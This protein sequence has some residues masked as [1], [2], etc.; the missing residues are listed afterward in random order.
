MSTTLLLVGVCLDLHLHS[1]RGTCGIT[2]TMSRRG[3][4]C[5]NPSRRRSLST[6]P[7]DPD[8]V[9]EFYPA[10]ALEFIPQGHRSDVFAN[11][12][13]QSLTYVPLAQ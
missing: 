8:L 11:I 3:T 6:C 10:D 2:S 1:G 4:H 7:R 13:C 12:E 5:R 9:L